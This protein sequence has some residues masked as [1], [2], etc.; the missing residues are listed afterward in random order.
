MPMQSVARAM[1]SAIADESCPHGAKHRHEIEDQ[2]DI[3]D[4]S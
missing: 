2:Y 1:K 4:E 3:P